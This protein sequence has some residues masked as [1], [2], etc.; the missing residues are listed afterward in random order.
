M[1]CKQDRKFCCI[2]DTLLRIKEKHYP[3]VKDWKTVLQTISPRKQ[4]G[5]AILISDKIDFQPKLLS[6]DTHEGKIYQEELSFL[7]IIAPNTRTTAF[8]TDT[9]L[10]LKA[11]L[12][13]RIIIVGNLNTQ[14]S[15]VD[16]SGKLKLNRVTVKLTEVLHQ[17]NLIDIYRAL[18]PLSK[19]YTFFLALQFYLF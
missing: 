2:Q 9:L 17:M 6:K 15:P 4:A 12:A 5:L 13:Q 10:K 14:F 16:R 1:I 8:I 7:N 11:W 18:H 19:G 3:R